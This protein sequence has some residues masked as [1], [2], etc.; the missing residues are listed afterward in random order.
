MV[1]AVISGNPDWVEHLPQNS[2]L[3]SQNSIN[4]AILNERDANIV[5]DSNIEG[6]NLSSFNKRDINKF[7]NSSVVVNKSEIDRLTKRYH[8]NNN[9]YRKCLFIFIIY[10]SYQSFE[11]GYISIS[12]SFLLFVLIGN[13][14]CRLKMQ[15]QS[16]LRKTMSL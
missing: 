4:E 5:N 14:E 8:H 15:I 10:I 11:Y 7:L 16:C 12:I 13:K 3:V 6:L 9:S 2:V 1:I